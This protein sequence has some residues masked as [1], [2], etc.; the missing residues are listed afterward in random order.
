[1]AQTQASIADHL[2][3]GVSERYLH[4]YRAL[5]RIHTL[6]TSCRVTHR[7]KTPVP[8]P[9]LTP[10]RLRWTMMLT[11]KV[12]HQDCHPE[13]TVLHMPVTDLV[14]KHVIQVTGTMHRITGGG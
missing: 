7:N 10:G 5:I 2:S 12:L 1:M 13:L 11:C 14:L 9:S 6:L 3:T 8:P 4:T